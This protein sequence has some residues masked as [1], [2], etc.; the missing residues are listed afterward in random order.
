MHAN[1]R[2]FM[3]LGTATVAATTL[4]GTRTQAAAS[5]EPWYSR[6][7]RWGQINI[8]ENNAGDMDIAFWRSYWRETEVQ[9]MILNAGGVAAFYP[10]RIPFH[11]R[12]DSLGNRDLFG[13]LAQACKEDGL[14]LCARLSY[15][16]PNAEVFKAHPDWFCVDAQG[17]RTRQACMNGGYIYE[18]TP[19][20]VKE[21]AANYRP[22]GFSL[23]AW[24]ANY[25]LCYCGVCKSLFKEKTGHD[26]PAAKN[27]DD[28]VYRDSRWSGLYLGRSERRNGDR[29]QHEGDSR[30]HP[31][32]HARPPGA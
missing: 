32:D 9:G 19:L 29:A 15:G 24:G 8:T 17:N 31:H 25:S 7:K 16:Y 2:E 13:E 11:H 30:P 12:P 21:V 14:V 5:A 4:A 28:P 23:S 3:I 26:L 27:W 18:Y 1:R 6:V 20:I 10:T 22:A